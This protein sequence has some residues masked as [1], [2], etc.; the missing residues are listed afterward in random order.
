M[1]FAVAWLFLHRL[2]RPSTAPIILSRWSQLM[3]RPRH[4]LYQNISL[5]DTIQSDTD[6]LCIAEATSVSNN[7]S[8]SDRI[9]L[10]VPPSS[11]QT[12][13]SLLFRLEY[14]RNGNTHVGGGSCAQQRGSHPTLPSSPDSPLRPCAD[15]PIFPSS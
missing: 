11:L 10:I 3:L 2:Q 4:S 8:S 1:A 15:S 14:R 5:P 13:S 7:V 12:V 6:P 9:H